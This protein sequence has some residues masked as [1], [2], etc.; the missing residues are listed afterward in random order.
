MPIK[1]NLIMEIKKQ[2]IYKI[3]FRIDVYCCGIISYAEGHTSVLACSK[4]E[5]EKKVREN[6]K[7]TY[8]GAIKVNVVS[9]FKE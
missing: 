3:H 6:I 9:D 8:N 4:E 5:A 2:K 7:L 1:Q